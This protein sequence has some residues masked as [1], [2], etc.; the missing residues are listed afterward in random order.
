MTSCFLSFFI[1]F[2]ALTCQLYSIH[3]GDQA[4]TLYFEKNSIRAHLNRKKCKQKIQKKQPNKKI[5]CVLTARDGAGMF[6]IFDDVLNLIIQYEEGIFGGVEVDFGRTGLYYDSKYGKN[7]WSYYCEPI[8]YRRISSFLIRKNIKRKMHLKTLNMLQNDR[9]KV[10]SFISKYF[11][12]KKHVKDKIDA[13]AEK[14]FTNRFVISV[15]Y[16]G[17]DKILEAPAVSYESVA[18]AVANAMQEYGDKPYTIF[19]ATDEQAFIDYMV[20]LFG[21]QVC[22][23]EDA[24]RSHDGKPVHFNKNYSS[25]QCGEDAIVDCVLLSKGNLLIRCS[26]NLSRWST[27]F[28]PNIPEVKLNNQYNGRLMASTKK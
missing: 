16:R 19:L 13:F 1:S 26:S 10:F 25:Y 8:S 4:T 6:S 28:N 7:W 17:T 11:H 18:H 3:N 27:Y 21:Q 24:L 20:N 23:N 12:I 22:Y 14:N 5:L 9:A 2:I 15:H